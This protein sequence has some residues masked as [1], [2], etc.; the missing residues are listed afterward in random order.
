MLLQDGF[1]FQKHVQS[2]GRFFF[3]TAVAKKEIGVKI[4]IATF[5]AKVIASLII[6]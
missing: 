5:Q 6:S 4:T 2:F 1:C 3:Y